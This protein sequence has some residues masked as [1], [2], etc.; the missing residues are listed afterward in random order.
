MGEAVDLGFFAYF[1]FGPCC[2]S[3][4]GLCLLLESQTS[5]QTLC[6]ADISQAELLFKLEFLAYVHKGPRI[7][8]F[9]EVSPDLDLRV[10][11]RKL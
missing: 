1:A 6:L 7:Q 9:E 4:D 5:S 3:F 11:D 10:L 2:E 8:E